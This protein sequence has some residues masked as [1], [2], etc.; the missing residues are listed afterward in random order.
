[1]RR[2]EGVV[3][4]RDGGRRTMGKNLVHGS[5]KLEVLDREE[6]GESGFN[7]TSGETSQAWQ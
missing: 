5:V 6:T 7:N 4:K 2:G 1:M 3:K